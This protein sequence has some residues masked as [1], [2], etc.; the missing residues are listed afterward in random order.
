MVGSREVKFALTIDIIHIHLSIVIVDIAGAIIRELGIV[1]CSKFPEILC[2]RCLSKSVIIPNTFTATPHI[3]NDGTRD[4]TFRVVMICLERPRAV[5]QLT[6]DVHLKSQG[7]DIAVL[8]HGSCVVS[9]FARRSYSLI[10]KLILTRRRD[11]L[12]TER[13]TNPAIQTQVEQQRRIEQV[14]GA[15]AQGGVKIIFFAQRK[16]G[17]LGA[18]INRS[19]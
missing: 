4:T 15:G 7:I 2:E 19:R 5:A 11:P 8:P 12:G 6:I 13:G 1:K 14:K 10:S 17:H 18:H 9:D 16:F 3:I